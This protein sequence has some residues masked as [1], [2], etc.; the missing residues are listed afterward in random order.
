MPRVD[1]G[2]NIDY[3]MHTKTMTRMYHPMEVGFSH[4]YAVGA[5]FSNMTITT[6]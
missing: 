2:Y 3:M 1:R 6:P 5:D 4:S